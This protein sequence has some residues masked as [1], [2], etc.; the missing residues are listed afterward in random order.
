M[1][2][3]QS[4][5]LH[6]SYCIASPG[7]Q[8]ENLEPDIGQP[9]RAFCNCSPLCRPTFP[10]LCHLHN[11]PFLTFFAG[12]FS[13]PKILFK[14]FSFSLSPSTDT[15]THLGRNEH[16]YFDHGKFRVWL[17][18]SFPRLTCL[19]KTLSS[20]NTI[21]SVLFLLTLHLKS[22]LCW[23]LFGWWVCFAVF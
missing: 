22:L 6:L 4:Y 14:A 10:C 3:D 7:K 20:F 13:L 18:N 1:W 19:P 11:F 21:S 12:S 8:V 2:R 17:F 23:Q 5:H 9:F 16:I 15:C